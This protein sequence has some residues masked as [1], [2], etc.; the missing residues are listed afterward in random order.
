MKYEDL[1]EQRALLI[2]ANT[3]S[4]S[5][6]RKLNNLERLIKNFETALSKLEILNNTEIELKTNLENQL[7]Y[8][9]SFYLNNTHNSLQGLAA[10]AIPEE[11]IKKLSPKSRKILKTIKRNTENVFIPNESLG[12]SPETSPENQTSASSK[13]ST[14][15]KKHNN[16]K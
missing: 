13:R 2:N 4:A 5:K 3:L 9:N 7:S 1:L 14:R 16:K 10:T 11:R 6:R 15:S 8:L 12:S